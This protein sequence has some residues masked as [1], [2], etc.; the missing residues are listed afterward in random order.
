[1]AANAHEFIARLPEG[2]DTVVGERGYTLSGGQRQRIAI[3]RTLLLNPPILVLDDA[4]S[5]IDVHIEQEIHEAL[6]ALLEHRTTLVIA[7]RLSTIALASRVI[8]LDGGKVAATGTHAE[9]LADVPALQRGPGEDRR[10][11]RPT[12]P[13]RPSTRTGLADGLGWR[14]RLRWRRGRRVRRRAVGL[15]VR[16]APLRRHPHRAAA[17]RRQDRRDRADARGGSKE[18]FTQRPSARDRQRLTIPLLVGEHPV[19]SRS[20]RCWCS[21]SGCS[22]SSAPTSSA[23][24]R[25]RDV[26]RHRRACTSPHASPWSSWPAVAYLRRVGHRR[27]LAARRSSD[28]TGRLAA[29]VM[30]RL[31]ILVFTH[32][33]RLSLDFFTEE[34]AG[35]LMS[36]MTS[37]SRTSSSSSRTASAPSPSSWSRW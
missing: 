12:W 18:F 37:T 23:G 15:D 8:L 25:P 2:Y 17:G 36:R 1:M 20:A 28:A 35:V 32:L 29:R 26:H 4:T 33:Q 11:T 16:G 34:K 5:S 31:R 19:L 10:S 6:G 24:N 9:L 3:A 14:R 21:S 13:M 7:H 27:V 22:A 30:H